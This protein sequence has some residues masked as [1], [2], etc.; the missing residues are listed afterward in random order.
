MQ[1]ELAPN[2]SILLNSR[3]SFHNIEVSIGFGDAVYFTSQTSPPINLIISD[4]YCF[5][6]SMR[7]FIYDVVTAIEYFVMAHLSQQKSK[8]SLQFIL[9]SLQPHDLSHISAVFAYK[10]FSSFCSIHQ[11]G[12]YIMG[13]FI[14]RRDM[15]KMHSSQKEIFLVFPHL[16]LCCKKRERDNDVDDDRRDR[17]RTHAG[18][19]QIVLPIQTEARF[20]YFRIFAGYIRAAFRTSCFDSGRGLFWQKNVFLG[21]ERWDFSQGLVATKFTS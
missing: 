14:F 6:N 7:F 15:D 10:L 5:E 12:S 21:S 2:H 3:I 20:T 18:S 4:W 13:A 17:C 9:F 19:H 16:L 1:Q 11:S 8:P